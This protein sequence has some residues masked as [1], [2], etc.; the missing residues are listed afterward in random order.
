MR[1]AIARRAPT[2]ILLTRGDAMGE[3]KRRGTAAVEMRRLYPPAK[4]GPIRKFAFPAGAALPGREPPPESAALAET[5]RAQVRTAL[6]KGSATRSLA[7]MEDAIA[8]AGLAAAAAFE[9]ALAAAIAEDGGKARE[10]ERI[11]CRRG[12]AF[13]CYVD[14]AVTP[15]EAIRLMRRVPAPTP[16][17]AVA[18]APRRAPCPMLV[19]GLCSA[20]EARP[21]ACRS[22]FSP[23]ARRCEAGYASDA[24]VAVPSLDWP[25]DLAACYI[26]GELAALADV[27]L[28][29][30]MVNL[31][32]GLAVLAEAGA[33]ARWLN[34]ASIFG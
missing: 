18:P 4:L 8:E 22:L 1:A 3:A 13:C 5:V 10:M 7:R 26:S 34:G 32:R 27:G 11:A 31:R 9:A 19:D 28:E 30:R 33:L 16:G 23:D 14:V 6:V 17:A 2:L 25:R 29:S 12:C 21:Y 24:P 20:Y 15:L